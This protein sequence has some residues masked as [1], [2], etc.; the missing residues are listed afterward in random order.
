M[1]EDRRNP[2]YIPKRGMF[3]EHDDRI[4]SDEEAEAKKKEQEEADKRRKKVW[5]SE[6]VNKWGHDKF[7][8]LDQA[9]KS[10]DELVEAYGYDIRDEDNAPRARRRR[11]YGRGPNKYTRNWEDEEAYEK[12]GGGEERRGG[13]RGGRGGGRGAA[14]EGGA[15]SGRGKI[16][17]GATRTEEDFPQL[18]KKEEKK[19]REVLQERDSKEREERSYRGGGR[20]GGRGGAS[21]QAYDRETRGFRGSRGGGEHEHRWEDNRGGRGGRGGGRGFDRDREERPLR[22]GRDGRDAGYDRDDRE[23]RGGR[24]GRGRGRGGDRDRD[25]IDRDM[26]RERDRDRDR[27]GD[28]ERG[29]RDW[30]DRRGRGRGG[31]RGGSSRGRGSGGGAGGGGSANS[32]LMKPPRPIQTREEDEE[33]NWDDDVDKVGD[34]SEEVRED[35]RPQRQQSRPERVKEQPPTK[36]MLR[37]TISE[38]GEKRVQKGGAAAEEKSQ[39]VR[40]DVQQSKQPK[41]Y[42]SLRQP[43]GEAAPAGTNNKDGSGEGSATNTAPTQTRP[44]GSGRIH[45]GMGASAYPPEFTGQAAEVLAAAFPSGHFPNGPPSG[46]PFNNQQHQPI[47]TAATSTVSPPAPV[48]PIAGA[49]GPPPYINPNGQII[50]YGPPPGLPHPQYTPAVTVPISMPPMSGHAAAAIP[51]HHDPSFA[52]NAALLAAAAAASAG[53]PAPHMVPADAAAHQQQVLLAAAAA[54]GAA[55]AGAN[56]A[57]PGVAEVRGGVTYFNPTAQ[58][59]IVRQQV[60][61]K[62][63]KAAIPIVDPSQVPSDGKEAVESEMS[64][65]SSVDSNSDV[66]AAVEA[67]PTSAS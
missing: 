7:L 35:Q 56:A 15:T 32:R 10:K 49:A 21:D 12:G 51:G 46:A 65:Q 42:S 60:V 52:A 1:D 36:E 39:D 62:R 66:S 20:G 58:Q 59:P 25:R 18:P 11:R 28:W 23:F 14:T 19:E 4:D 45:P 22:G 48:H 13:R 26:H 24:G 16:K 57:P 5:K 50:N 34:W 9:P 37:V 67:P 38:S 29:D 3:Y 53:A 64:P 43:K 2:Q 54:A 8:E 61:S 47:V 63:P 40:Q 6:A 33:I 27:G 55:A 30:G 41:R 31:D 17:A 44:G